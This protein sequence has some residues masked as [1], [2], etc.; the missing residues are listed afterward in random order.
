MARR[1][2]L[3]AILFSSLLEG[4]YACRLKPCPCKTGAYICRE[5]P[6]RADEADAFEKLPLLSLCQTP[7]SAMLPY[8]GFAPCED[9]ADIVSRTGNK[10]EGREEC[11]GV[12]LAAHVLELYDRLSER[13]GPVDDALN[14][15]AEEI[16]DGKP[17]NAAKQRAYEATRQLNRSSAVRAAVRAALGRGEG[18]GAPGSEGAAGRSS[19]D[20]AEEGRGREER[21]G[22][23]C[24]RAGARG[25]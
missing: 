25:L 19:D 23:A 3:R 2:Y 12:A 14:T 16:S 5:H 15:A 22:V 6:T 20:L 10:I 21:G 13:R 7:A 8:N 11:R 24:G 17:A 4:R 18:A 1:L 9:V